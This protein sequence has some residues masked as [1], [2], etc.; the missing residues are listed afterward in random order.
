VI[1]LST[2]DESDHGVVFSLQFSGSSKR[3]GAVGRTNSKTKSSGGEASLMTSHGVVGAQTTSEAPEKS[4]VF[5]TCESLELYHLVL[6]GFGMIL[7]HA[8][9]A[10]SEP[11]NTEVSGWLLLLLVNNGVSVDVSLPK[12]RKE[13]KRRHS[14]MPE[15]QHLERSDVDNDDDDG[16]GCE[17]PHIYSL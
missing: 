14:S 11:N 4:E 13:K 15:G 3:R 2:V 12:K 8:E 5:F 10:V 6:D 7:E 16:G 1:D 17:F 9:A